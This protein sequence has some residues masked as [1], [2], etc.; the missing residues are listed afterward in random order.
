MIQTKIIFT[1][2]YED[3]LGKIEDFIFYSSQQEIAVLEWFWD[4]QD[5]AL[6]FIV[7]NPQIPAVHPATG[8][9][10]WPF[11]DGRYRIFFKYI[12]HAE[13]N[14]VYLTHII[15]NRQ[16]NLKVYSGNKMPTYDED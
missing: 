4:E 11:A 9:Q 16:A 2:A 13:S 3:A 12:T 14:A 6:Q 1:E 15:D 7:E 8:D 10:S 5:H